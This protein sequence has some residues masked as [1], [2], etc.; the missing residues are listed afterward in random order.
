MFYLIVFLSLLF[1]CT[2]FILSEKNA[3]YILSGYNTMSK[4]EQANYNLKTYVLAFRNFHIF[5][6]LSMLAV[7]LVLYFLVAKNTALIFVSIYPILAYAFFILRSNQS[8]SDSLKRKNRLAS[9]VLLFVAVMV[10]TLF[11]RGMKE[12]KISI[13]DTTVSF[14]GMY[15]EVVDFQDIN[16]VELVKKLPKIL[17][18]VHGYAMDGIYKG[19]FKTANDDMVKLLINAENMPYIKIER[20]NDLTIFFASKNSDNQRIFEDLNHKIK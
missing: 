5:L 4:E 2:G 13:N 9:L 10:G 8:I 20:K 11:Y 3:S 19:K 1:L 12:T 7:G 15:G 18:K 14:K 6:G 17:M 16:S